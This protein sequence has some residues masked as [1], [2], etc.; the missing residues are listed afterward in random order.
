MT[1]RPHP[2]ARAL[3]TIAHAVAQMPDG[4]NDLVCMRCEAPPVGL[5][6]CPVCGS[7]HG[8]TPRRGA[9][10]LRRQLGVEP[11]PVFGPGPM[12]PPC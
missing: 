10:Q 6:P 8:Y 11:H 12:E 7:R 4:V 5:G 3:D 1:Q 2:W 9:H